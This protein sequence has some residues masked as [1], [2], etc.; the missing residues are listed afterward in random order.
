[1]RNWLVIAALLVAAISLP[2]RAAAQ[3][4]PATD[5]PL[6]RGHALLIG[7][8]HYRA[9]PRLDDVPLQLDELAE[10]IKNHFETV[11]VVKDLEI[12]LL[13]QKINGFLRSYGN[14]SNARLFIY[15]AGHGYTETILPY[16]ENRGYITG[17]D[18]PTVDGSARGYNAAR[19]KAM[20]MMEIRSPLAEVLAK[21]GVEAARAR[22]IL[23]ILLRERKLVRVS[24]ELVFHQA[25]IAQLRE[26]LAVLNRLVPLP[27]DTPRDAQ[28]PPEWFKYPPI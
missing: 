5:D 20:S 25:A 15:Y 9:W 26:L 3:M 11:E 23:Q 24:D 17:I 8:S 6:R 27:G 18:T 7:N 19:P 4:L 16:N 28:L 22:S 13:R 21:A 14:D 2:H 12:D 1:M 10:G